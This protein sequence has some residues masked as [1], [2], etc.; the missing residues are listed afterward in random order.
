MNEDD[1]EQEPGLWGTMHQ[2]K[3]MNELGVDEHYISMNGLQEINLKKENYHGL[4]GV[5]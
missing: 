5:L 2:R 1:V 3:W 4:F